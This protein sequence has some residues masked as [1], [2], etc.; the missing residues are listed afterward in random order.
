MIDADD[1][2]EAQASA[3]EREIR[4]T[5]LAFVGEVL[6]QAREEIG[7]CEETRPPAWASVAE[8]RECEVRYG[9]RRSMERLVAVLVGPTGERW[10]VRACAASDAGSC[11]EQPDSEATL[12]WEVAS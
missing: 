11:W 6:A 8:V 1:S 3:R 4:E 2:I 12:E 5:P 10:L 7:D 9:G